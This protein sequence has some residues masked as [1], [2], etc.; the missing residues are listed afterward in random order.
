MKGPFM[1]TPSEKNI[2]RETTYSLLS[3]NVIAKLPT[4]TKM[5]VAISYKFH[6]TQ[7]GRK[8]KKK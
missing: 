7:K 1:R 5:F 3:I 2:F 4:A 6:I 8:I